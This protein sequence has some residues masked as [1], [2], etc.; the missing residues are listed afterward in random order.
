MESYG[1]W[2]VSTEADVE[3]RSMKNLGDFTGHIDEIAL[4]LADQC[5][6]T[7]WFERIEP[8]TTFVPK[9]TSVSIS[10]KGVST[11]SGGLIFKHRPVS[12]NFKSNSVLEIVSKNP[13][14]II[15]ERALAKLTA[16]ERKA[17]GLK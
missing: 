12:V 17:L 11:R 10:I 6:Y 3:G 2:R 7:L 4:H 5:Y 13:E 16:E 15:R 14:E 1:T 8:I 9:E